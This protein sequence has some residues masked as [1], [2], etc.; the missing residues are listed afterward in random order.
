MA[1]SITV[2]RGR[3]GQY[4]VPQTALACVRLAASPS[5][6]VTEV[7]AECEVSLLAEGRLDCLFNWPYGNQAAPPSWRVGCRTRLD[8][9]RRR[10]H[11]AMRAPYLT[12]PFAHSTDPAPACR[13]HQTSP[14]QY[15]TA[16]KVIDQTGIR[17]SRRRHGKPRSFGAKRNA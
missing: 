16:R 4:L 2:P 9:S 7:P 17:A 14:S 5:D 8:C 1:E 6:H 12:G 15:E 3:D 10:N 13:C 11:M